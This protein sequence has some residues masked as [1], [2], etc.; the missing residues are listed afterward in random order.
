MKSSTLRRSN[1]TKER[2]QT[3]ELLSKYRRK[4]HVGSTSNLQ[5]VK[6]KEIDMLWQSLKQNA[7]EE[8]SPTVYLLTGFILGAVSMLILTTIISL[9]VNSLN[10]SNFEA[11]AAAPVVEENAKLTFIPAD[12][13]EVKNLTDESYVV[14]KGDTLESI[15]IRFYGSYSSDKARKIQDANNLSNPNAIRIGQKLNVPMN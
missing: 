5:P 15:V 8:K 1:L 10:E 2:L 3:I 4:N 12:T 13:T 7:K 9:S 6:E 14:Q 11:P